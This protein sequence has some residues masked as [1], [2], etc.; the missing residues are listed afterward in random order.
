MGGLG[1][2]AVASGIALLLG[3]TDRE[4]TVDEQNAKEKPFRNDFGEAWW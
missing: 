2:I 1:G 3:A 4:K